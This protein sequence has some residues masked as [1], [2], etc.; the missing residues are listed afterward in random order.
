MPTP[1]LRTVK[2]FIRFYIA[3]S[4]PRLNTKKKRPTADSINIVAEWFFIGFTRIIGIDTV[5]EERSEVYN[6]RSSLLLGARFYR[7]EG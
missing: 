2:D 3:I 5:E 6:V 4:K 1:D 7:I